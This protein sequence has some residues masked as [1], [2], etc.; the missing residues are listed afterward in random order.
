MMKNDDGLM[1]NDEGWMMQWRMM[2]SSCWGVLIYDGQTDG[3][4]D[5]QADIGDCRVAFTT[6]KREGKKN[7][8]IR[9]LAWH[10]TWLPRWLLTSFLCF[11]WC[12]DQFK[13]CTMVVSDDK[14]K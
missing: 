6:E 1:K 12:F 4:M 14:W 2:I 10:P 8:N 5:K 7:I 3:R 13:Y 11:W 9:L